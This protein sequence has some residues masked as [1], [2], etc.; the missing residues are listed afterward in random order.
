MTFA[1]I[2][3]ITVTPTPHGLVLL[4]ERNGRY[5]VVNGTG[6]VVLQHLL[7]GRAQDAAVEDLRTRFPDAADEIA[8][9]VDNLLRALREAEVIAR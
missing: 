9:D 5:W 2:P 7:D 8:A 1:L 3:D 6:A 4:N